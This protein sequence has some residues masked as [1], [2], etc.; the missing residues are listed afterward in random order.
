MLVNGYSPFGVL[1]HRTFT[2]PRA[3]TVLADPVVLSIAAAHQT[4]PAIVILAW[5]YKL[6]IPFNPRSMNAAHM[7][8]NIGATPTPWWELAL[9]PDEMTALNS[10]PQA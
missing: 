6:G 1:D 7:L 4:S 3:L 9:T 2:P 8:E 5:H 10:R